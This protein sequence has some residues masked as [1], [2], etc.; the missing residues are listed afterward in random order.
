MIMAT[1]GAGVYLVSPWQGLNPCQPTLQAFRPQGYKGW[2]A[3]Y[4]KIY[5]VK[6]SNNGIL[7]V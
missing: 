1:L 6:L 3:L 2:P 4:G 7:F 5:G